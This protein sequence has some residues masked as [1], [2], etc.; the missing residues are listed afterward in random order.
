MNL[1]VGLFEFYAPFLE[2]DL[3]KREA[4]DENG[5]VKAV[6]SLCLY[7]YLIGDL[8]LVL[9]PV[10]RVEETNPRTLSVIQLKVL[11]VTEFLCLLKASSSFEV[12]K[13]LVELRLCE[14]STAM[15]FELFEI[16]FF[17]LHFKIITKSIL[18]FEDDSFVTVVNEG[19][20]QALFQHLLAL[21]RHMCVCSAVNR[22]A[23]LRIF[24]R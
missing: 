18:V 20:N 1:V 3:H 17:E 2:F 4:I 8:E 5:N 24:Y 14:G 11:E 15:S 7:C 16:M 10:F 22:S 6:L 13:N 9:A 23:K 12:Q 21:S 19:L